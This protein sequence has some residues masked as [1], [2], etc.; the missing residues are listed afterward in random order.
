MSQV[1]D[2][3][4]GIALYNAT[5]NPAAATISMRGFGENAAANTLILV[6]GF[7]L[8]NPDMGATDINTIP[9]DTI[10]AI[11][12][13]PGSGGILY[14]EDAVGGVVNIITKTP[15]HRIG[16]LA[17]SIG[18]YNAK[19]YR[20]LIGDRI[21]PEIYYL[22][23]GQASTDDNYRQYN[24]TQ[25]S[26]VMA[27]FGYDTAKGHVRAH[28][29][30]MTLHQVLPGALPQESSPTLGQPGSDINSH[31]QLYSLRFSQPLQNM[32][33]WEGQFASR[34]T[35]TNGYLLSDFTQY[36]QITSFMPRAIG[37]LPWHNIKTVLGTSIER[38]D[39]RYTIPAYSAY[40]ID[41]TRHAYASYTHMTIPL[42]GALSGTL[43]ARFAQTHSVLNGVDQNDHVWVSEQG[44]RYDLSPTWR[45]YA[46]RAG[47]YRF[48]K[49][50]ETTDVTQS[51]TFL[52]TQTGVSYETGISF[53]RDHQSLQWDVY[54]LD[55]T[56]EIAFAPPVPNDPLGA[57]RNLDPTRR[58]G[59]LLRFDQRVTE[60]T[61]A[62]FNANYTHAYYR[63]GAFSGKS[64][65]FVPRVTTSL[66]VDQQWLSH[67]HAFFSAL[68]TGGRYAAEDDANTDY[69]GGY[70]VYNAA[71]SYVLTH[72]SVSF[73]V[74][75]IFNKMYDSYVLLPAGTTTA[76]VYPAAGRH[77][78]LTVTYAL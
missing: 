50:D 48:P 75:N 19:L 13:I 77:F 71:I 42:V 66:G 76:Y 15:T 10:E 61:T 3:Q 45:W 69:W 57:N 65:P 27:E 39:Y 63:S 47:N 53:H 6:N 36:R 68:Y 32:W 40:D 49:A 5:G 60:K 52:K 17:T 20:A 4:A 74:D 34:V 11:H 16:E 59:M 78:S 35:H 37:V 33:H 22:L 43:G 23:Q 26:N 12:I 14:G 51:A 25:E 21:T 7:P 62:L 24:R 30:T 73:R 54:Q 2:H 64:I 72:W 41:D 58:R 38:D 55:L 67:W 1:L 70:T 56:N 31:V 44:V 18:S 8:I 28:V 46:R 9:L 29:D